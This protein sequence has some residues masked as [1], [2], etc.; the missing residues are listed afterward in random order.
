MAGLIRGGEVGMRAL[1]QGLQSF[2]QNSQVMAQ[3]QA[4]T[5]SLPQHLQTLG[6]QAIQNYNAYTGTNALATA[7][8]VL[9]AAAELGVCDGIHVISTVNGFQ[10]ANM[11]MQRFMMANPVI[12]ELA[13]DNRIC[14]WADSFQDFHPMKDP[15][16]RDDYRMS[17]TGTVQ[18]T[19]E[20]GEEGR[21]ASIGWYTQPNPLGIYEP[22]MHERFDIQSSWDVLI[23]IVNQ[24]E[25]GDPTSQFNDQF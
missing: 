8:Q 3:L 24:R 12:Y 4:F 20:E 21:I 16:Q 10:N 9:T 14:G 11:A 22:T 5:A 7:R 23:H 17:I 13:A 19:E 25:G 2:Q 15:L 1:T 6:Q 18:M